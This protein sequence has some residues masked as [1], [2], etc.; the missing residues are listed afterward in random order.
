MPLFIFIIGWVVASFI[1]TLFIGTATGMAL[2]GR[3][4]EPH[5][6]RERTATIKT[7]SPLDDVLGLGGLS[8]RSGHA[9]AGAASRFS[10]SNSPITARAKAPGR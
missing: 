1:F 3:T 8:G 4:G 7:A 6:T 5:L 2:R 9:M 10:A